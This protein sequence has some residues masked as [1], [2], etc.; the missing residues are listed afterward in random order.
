M[1]DPTLA[2]HVAVI[3]AL[4]AACSCDVWDGVP[5]DTV[6]YPY[7]VLDY[8]TSDNDDFLNSERMDWRYLF[9]SIWSRAEGQAEVIGIISEIE[10]T[11]NE[12]TLSLST[13]Q[14]VSLRVDRK[15]TSR[16]DDNLTYQGQV[17]LRIITTH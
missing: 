14:C 5:Q 16:H 4:D 2:L 3:A 11:M 12:Q 9:L 13:G 10:D 8:Q 7:I 17:V 1:A 6:S 15:R